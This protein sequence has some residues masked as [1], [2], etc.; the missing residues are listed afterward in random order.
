MEMSLLGK[1][2]VITGGGGDIGSEI[3]R[4]LAAF[5]TQ[6]II[7]HHGGTGQERAEKVLKTL[8]GN[9]HMAVHASV[10]SF[11]EQKQL[12]AA[13]RESYGKFDL[14]VNN[15][16]MTRFVPADDLDEHDDYRFGAGS[17]S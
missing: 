9:G 14:L 12:A 16:G 7:T 10:D 1:V 17:C 4:T 6:V 2:A 8:D 5:G 11:E 15:A 13:V 3:C